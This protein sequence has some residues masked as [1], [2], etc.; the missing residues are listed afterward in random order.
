MHDL[1]NLMQNI[2]V[3]ALILII[4]LWAAGFV[5]RL[6]KKSSAKSDHIDPTLA[7]F[8]ASLAKYAIIALA[9]TSALSIAGFPATLFATILGAATL[10]IGFALQGTLGDLA[11]GVMIIMFR[12]YKLGDF[13]EIA[14]EAGGVKNITIFTTELATV[15]NKKIIVPNGQAWGSVITN[16]SAHDT[17]RVDMVFGIDYDD[18]IDK[19]MK[20]IEGVAKRDKR[21]LRDPAPFCAVSNLG[22]SSVDIT[23]RLWCATSDYW[24]IKFDALKNVKEA[25]DAGGVSIPY[26]HKV[27]VEKTPKPATA[28]AHKTSARRAAVKKS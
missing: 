2:A 22:D 10:A 24:G 1:V 27:G 19:A 6:I 18:D 12:P 11:A 5:V 8:F 14:G 20:I 13:I 28:P 25:F 26:P 21:V 4:G 9:A 3:A 16:Y 15:D 7:S 23:V 17:R